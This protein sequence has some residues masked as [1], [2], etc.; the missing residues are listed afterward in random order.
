MSPPTTDGHT[1]SWL[2]P[3]LSMHDMPPPIYT[4]DAV[5]DDDDK[6]H[7]Q[8]GNQQDVQ[9]T[10]TPVVFLSEDEPVKVTSNNLLILN[11]KT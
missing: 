1:G 11:N 2:L 10:K 5:E 9:V 7:Q 3:S 8:V 6:D 4:L